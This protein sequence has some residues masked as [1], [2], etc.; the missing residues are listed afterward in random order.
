MTRTDIVIEQSGMEVSAE[1]RTVLVAS[2]T[3]ASNMSGGRYSDHLR[4]EL[5]TLARVGSVAYITQY[6]ESTRIVR[7]IGY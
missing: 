3:R 2:A 4:S 6:N 1:E 7:E 5:A